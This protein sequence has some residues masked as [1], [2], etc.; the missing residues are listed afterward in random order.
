VYEAREAH[1]LPMRDVPLAP[2]V[3]AAHAA[4]RSELPGYIHWLPV[5]PKKWIDQ[6]RLVDGT[7]ESPSREGWP[8]VVIDGPEGR[9][10][11]TDDT[12]NVL[13]RVLNAECIASRFS[14]KTQGHH[15]SGSTFTDAS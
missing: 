10:I 9:G 11:Y 1:W 14:A 12:E 15:G 8:G 13:S 7:S 4:D 3:R 6:M 2:Y 5:E